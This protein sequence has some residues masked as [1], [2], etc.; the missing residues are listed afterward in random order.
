MENCHKIKSI[1]PGSIAEELSLSPG[2]KLLRINGKKIADIFDYHYLA[3]DEYL[4]LLVQKS[5]G[6]EWELEIEKDYG[7]DLGLVFEDGLMDQYRSCRNKCIFC[8]IDQMP[9]GMRETL[10]FK[11]DDARLSF[12]QGNYITLTNMSD[13]DVKRICF[14]K[15][16]P[17]NISIHTMNPALRCKMLNNRFA[18][19]AL[20]KIWDFFDA[21]ITMNAQ[22]VLCKG[23]NDGAELDFTIG[24]LEK[25]LP[26]MESVS[27]VPVG[28]TKYREGLF[29]LESFNREDARAVLH[30]IFSWQEKMLS[31][32]KTRFVHASDEWFLTA[33]W[34]I[35]E[36]E[37]YEGYGQIENGVGMARSLMDE[38]S[39]ALSSAKFSPPKK[40][41]EISLATGVLAVP[42]LTGLLESIREKFPEITVHLYPIINHFFGEEI[43]VAGLVTG[44]DLVA[45]LRGKPLGE[46]LLIPSVM[47]RPKEYDFL[48]DYTIKE[49][50]STLQTRVRIVQSDGMS[51]VRAI[52]EPFSQDTDSREGR[53]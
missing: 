44:Q 23:I 53:D 52:V 25:F 9:P 8:F 21:G 14:Y 33:G 50:E 46:Y 34:P 51:F 17:I 36:A 43:T 20:S 1:V 5:S 4:T 3:N 19:D 28:K 18:G 37:Y 27:V 24:E 45:Q 30:Q 38:V 2:D 35:P 13:E 15:L 29:P 47:I 32:H 16:S 7:E 49:V 11:D 22:I 10:Y 6:E 42:I 39:A 26:Y 12:L 41:K 48:D 31:R 40:S